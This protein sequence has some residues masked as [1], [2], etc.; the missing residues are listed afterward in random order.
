MSKLQFRVLYRQF[1]FRM[2]DLE[3]LSSAAQGDINKLLGRFAGVLVFASAWLAF[4][5]LM[6]GLPPGPPEIH[7][8]AAWAMEHFLIASTM[9]VVGL[10]AVFSW[11]SMFPDRRDV[12]VLAPLPVRSRTLFVAKVAA[13]ATALGLSLLTVNAFTG[14]STPMVYGGVPV[15]SPPHDDPAMPPVKLGELKAVLDHDLAPAMTA[16][17][18]LA[19][20]SGAGMVI[21]VVENGERRI[22][23]YGIAKPDSIFE[24]GSISKTFTGLI[25]ARMVAGGRVKLDEPVR[26][27]LPP[28]TVAKP[29]GREITLL[30]LATH[31]SGLPPAPDNVVAEGRPNP[32]A[33]YHAPDLYAYLSKQGVSKPADPTFVYSNLGFGVLGQA[34]AERAGKTYAELLRAEVT[35]PLG[36]NDTS[37][38][39]TDD[40]QA[41]VLKGYGGFHSPAPP[42]DMGVF[43]PAGSIRSTAGDM[44]TYLEAQLH[45]EKFPALASALRES[46][47]VHADGTEG[48]HV[49]IAW[50]RRDSDEAYWHNGATSGYT[51]DV[52]F[53][54]NG[55]YAGVI[56]YNTGPAVLGSFVGQLGEHLRQRLAGK[57]AVSL[58]SPLKPANSFRLFEAY[59][60]AI[61]ATGVF[62]FGFVL[63]LQGFAQL[64]PRQTFLRA[65][66]FLQIAAFGLF[67]AMYFAQLPFAS[68]EDLLSPQNQKLL[69]WLPSYWFFGMLQQLDG[70]SLFSASATMGIFATRAWTGLALA[71]AGAIAAYLMCY[72]RTLRKVAEQ[73]DILPAR[74]GLHWLPKFGGT[75]QTA[76]AQFSIRTFARSRKHR[77]TLAFYLGIAFAIVLFIA[78]DPAAQPK[79]SEGGW[80]QPNGPVIFATFAA[81]LAAVAGM[82]IAF[83]MP[84]DLRANWIFRVLPLRG[85]VEYLK[86]TRRPLY[87][88]SLAPAWLASAA[89]V[90][91]LWPW[92]PAAEHLAI[93]GLV[94]IILAETRLLSF[95]K[96]P[97]TCSYLPGKA[98]LAVYLAAGA[99][100]GIALS[101]ES[102]QFE[103]NALTHEQRNLFEPLAGLPI[104][105]FTLRWYASRQARAADA[106]EFEDLPTPAVL[107]LG[108]NRDG[109]S[110]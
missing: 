53:Q 3:L 37:I 39:L 46:H 42:I 94:G 50:A 57:P 27:L 44:L 90:L 67:V 56:L 92:K 82:R 65:S 41:R 71:V 40:R 76:V 15:I 72:F 49:A 31:H 14:L 104:A 79:A 77:L 85:G 86:A 81:M 84:L 6:G 35:E 51:S 80:H 110:A 47:V 78:R 66:S 55:D 36:L 12:L 102:I 19:P 74:A 38:S 62:T 25:L 68:P 10:F 106:I 33:N 23:T 101:V 20:D 22:L 4:G 95:R 18:S 21:G 30:D 60:V 98:N 88:L 103:L 13:V 73:P 1:L 93:L 63:S 70:S 9:L 32:A 107:R 54:P 24:I 17:G 2:V 91:W 59:W 83:A 58:A 16:D 61:I 89:V 8:I 75:L 64:L 97:F 5:M 96:I 108:L 43:A 52:F 26:E 7:I 34:L 11:D 29:E 87:A 45:P 109:V 48:L 99:F 105:A 100:L 69:T 28:G